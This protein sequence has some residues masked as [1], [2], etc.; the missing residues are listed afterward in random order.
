MISRRGTSELSVTPGSE[1]YLSAKSDFS[2]LQSCQHVVSI[3]RSPLEL[4]GLSSHILYHFMLYTYIHTY[5]SINIT[6]LSLSLSL[7][8]S[9]AVIRFTGLQEAA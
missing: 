6:S 3:N 4:V 7:S 5:I 2:D 9:T 1:L 8:L